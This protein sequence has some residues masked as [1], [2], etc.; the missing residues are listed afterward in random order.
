MRKASEILDS[1]HVQ[2]QSAGPGQTSGRFAK[3]EKTE[4][5]T[6][7]IIHHNLR[8][9]CL[10]V[11]YANMRMCL[12]LYECLCVYLCLS[13]CLPVCTGTQFDSAT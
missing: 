3:K 2:I 1:V 4:S 7:E 10:H 5:P 9:E 13:I 11:A 12:F 6:Y 8:Q